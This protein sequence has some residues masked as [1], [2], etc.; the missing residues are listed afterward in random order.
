MKLKKFLY[1]LQVLDGRFQQVQEKLT[2]FAQHHQTPLQA[3]PALALPLCGA[4]QARHKRHCKP[5]IWQVDSSNTIRFANNHLCFNC[6]Q[7]I[8]LF[9]I[10]PMKKA[11]NQ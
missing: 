2:I 5:P 1:L 11:V 7:L 8:D 10:F 9:R 3:S 6:L 4:H